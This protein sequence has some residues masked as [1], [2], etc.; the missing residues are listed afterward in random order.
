MRRLYVDWNELNKMGESTESNVLLFEKA[1]L[2]FESE[3]ES[4]I[5]C[6]TGNDSA[7]YQTE[8]LKYLEE[9][10]TDVDYL[11]DWA[12]YFKRK[13]R[14]YNGTEEDSLQRVRNMVA[15][16]EADD[17]KYGGEV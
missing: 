14:G 6:W 9:L 11:Y 15:Q 10:K 4:L 13:A 2:Y 12:T 1:R 7:V 5:E 17:R 8:V 16:L 3:V